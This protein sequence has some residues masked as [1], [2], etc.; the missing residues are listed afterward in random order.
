[1]EINIKKAKLNEI[2]KV[3][4]LLKSAALWLKAE[5]IDYWQNWLNPPELHVDWIKQG[6]KN[7]EFYFV[8]DSENT[9]LGMYRLQYNDEMFWGQQNIKAGYIHSFTTNRKYKGKGIGIKILQ[10]IEKKLSDKGVDFLRLDCSPDIKGL[11]KYYESYGFRR[12][13]EPKDIGVDGFI[14]Q[15]YEKRINW[16]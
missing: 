8:Y 3:L 11:C 12:I 5:T 2:D 1:M 16:S 14:C 4:D 9:L 10:L 6:L 15:L 13:G 7:K